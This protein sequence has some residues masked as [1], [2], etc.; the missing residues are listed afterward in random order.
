MTL[1][2]LG[3][4]LIVNGVLLWAIMAA[5]HRHT[6]VLKNLQRQMEDLVRPGADDTAPLEGNPSTLRPRDI[7]RPRKE[8]V[9]SSTR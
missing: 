2:S 5:L 3:I 7:A 8:P 4:L 6:V 1:T 9:D